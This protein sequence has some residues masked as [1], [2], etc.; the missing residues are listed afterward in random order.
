MNDLFTYGWKMTLAFCVLIIFY[1]IVLRRETLHYFKRVYL[2]LT[3]FVAFLLPLLQFKVNTESA[4]YEFTQPLQ[5]IELHQVNAGEVAQAY[6]WEQYLFILIGIVAV[7]LL[8]YTGFGVLNVFT[9]ITN[10]TKKRLP[11]GTL[12]D[13]EQPVSPFSFF[14]Y[15]V[16]RSTDHNK[17]ELEN[18]IEHEQIHVYQK[19]YFD[20]LQAQLLT[21]FCWWNPLSWLYRH[22]VVENLE[23]IV[24][25][26]LLRSGVNKKNYQF[27]ILKTS[28]YDSSMVFANHFNQSLLKKRII[29]MNKELSNPKNLWRTV[30]VLPILLLLW[31]GVGQLKAEPVNLQPLGED[32]ETTFM[33][34][35]DTLPS[36]VEIYINGES[37]TKAEM[38]NLDRSTIESIEV[39]KNNTE[40]A[41]FIITKY[42]DDKVESVEEDVNIVIDDNTIAKDVMNEDVTIFLDEKL[43]SKVEME[44]LDPSLILSI[45]VKKTDGEQREIH[46]TSKSK[47]AFDTMQAD[48]HYI[49]VDDKQVS[50]TE[51][52]NKY[53]G[54]DFAYEK[55]INYN[56]GGDKINAKFYWTTKDAFI[57]RKSIK[58][59][60]EKCGLDLR[61]PPPPP[62]VPASPPPAAP[63]APQGNPPPPPPAP[64][65]PPTPQMEGQVYDFAEVAPEYPGGVNQ[66]RLDFQSLYEVPDISQEK[67]LTGT[68]VTRFVVNETGGVEDVK[69]PLRNR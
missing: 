5:L 8:C 7:G 3:P 45:D 4:I 53:K 40:K 34:K 66:I 67:R 57:N 68:I 48:I 26:E 12:C 51:F 33:E 23:F 1:H 25:Q 60:N 17:P 2:L 63:S 56:S 54:R 41:I 22:F 43:I 52:N 32:M 69:I 27:S 47:F 15:I 19:H 14:Q 9:F 31:I 11:I 6:Q 18:I 24:D 29:M 35:T 30:F 13:T 37:V 65:V 39:S 38:D 10:S 55:S 61:P 62:P 64:P 42:E 21:I 50:K 28:V 44:E 36:D 59:Y 16:L 58:W 49:F 20:M 46:I